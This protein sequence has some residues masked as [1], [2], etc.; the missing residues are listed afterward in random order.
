M[1]DV[2]H[3][4][5]MWMV[6]SLL[7]LLFP[8]RCFGCGKNMETICKRCLT[9]ARKSLSAPLPFIES[10]YDFR[11]PLIKRAIHAVKYKHRKELLKPLV[12]YAILMHPLFKQSTNFILIPVPMTSFRKL[13]RGYNHAEEI[14]RIINDHS[15]FPLRTDV[16]TRA[17]HTKRQAKTLKKAERLTNQRGSFASS[18][19]DGLHVLVIDDV[20]TTGATLEEARNILLAAGAAS[21]QAFTLAH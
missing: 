5:Y 15:A 19:V 3:L 10:Y 8:P 14:A 18:R 6:H 11:D 16:L 7:T 4:L 13:L 21:V 12:Q 9:L 1:T 17:R 2:L 20:S